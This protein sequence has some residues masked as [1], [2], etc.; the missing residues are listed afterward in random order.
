[1]CFSACVRACVRECMCWHWWMSPTWEQSATTALWNKHK[2]LQETSFFEKRGVRCQTLSC[3]C[4]CV[5]KSKRA[6]SGFL[7]VLLRER[8]LAQYSHIASVKPSAS[9]R[10]DGLVSPDTSLQTPTAL[11]CCSAWKFTLAQLADLHQIVSSAL[12]RAKLIATSPQQRR[13]GGGWLSRWGLSTFSVA[14]K[15]MG[16]QIF[17]LCKPMH[18]SILLFETLLTSGLLLPRSLSDE[19]MCGQP[20][21]TVDFHDLT[22]SGRRSMWGELGSF[23]LC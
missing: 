22:A 5:H 7:S 8:G 23:A 15:E 2:S 10:S 16:M 6:R 14:V 17:L 20:E 19:N 11:F 21:P 9:E 4:V 3:L 13:S 18:N 1:M 12:K